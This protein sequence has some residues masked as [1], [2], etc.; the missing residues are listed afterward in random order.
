DCP[1]LNA[2]IRGIVR[3]GVEVHGFE[4][5]GVRDGWRG[6]L[7]GAIVPLDVPAVRG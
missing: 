6:A 4:F 3:K 2:A 7:E 1:G 5:V